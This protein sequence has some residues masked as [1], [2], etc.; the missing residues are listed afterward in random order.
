[1]HRIDLRHG[2]AEKQATQVERIRIAA[3]APPAEAFVHQE[4][5]TGL[6]DNRNQQV[7]GERHVLAPADGLLHGDDHGLSVE[8]AEERC[9]KRANQ[10]ATAQPVYQLA[11]GPQ[12]H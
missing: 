12:P 1:V 8:R 10:G 2:V 5:V 4:S 6:F 11:Q 7:V 9:Q 3:L